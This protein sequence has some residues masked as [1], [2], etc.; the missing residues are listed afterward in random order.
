MEQMNNSNDNNDNSNRNN[1]SNQVDIDMTAIIDSDEDN[2]S[3]NMSGFGQLSS[4][5]RTPCQQS[6]S[7]KFHNFGGIRYRTEAVTFCQGCT[8]RHCVFCTMKPPPPPPGDTHCSCGMST[9]LYENRGLT[10]LRFPEMIKEIEEMNIKEK[11]KIKI[12]KAEKKEQWR[13]E[14]TTDS[15]TQPP[16]CWRCNCRA[17]IVPRE[18]PGDKVIKVNLKNPNAGGGK[19]L[20]YPRPPYY[21]NFNNRSSIVDNNMDKKYDEL[22]K[23]LDKLIN[24]KG[25]KDKKKKKSKTSKKKRRLSKKRYYSSTTSTTTSSAADTSEDST[26]EDEKVKK[27]KSKAKK[28]NKKAKG[29][30]LMKNEEGSTSK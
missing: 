22:K 21:N 25:N 7:S 16:H 24:E 20:N 1:E 15:T 12:T 23:Q 17:H 8:H 5:F 29:G 10:K 28:K 27:R 3:R 19:L 18:E 11:A 6:S 30:K 9:C 4:D 26:S 2:E 14:H 13:L